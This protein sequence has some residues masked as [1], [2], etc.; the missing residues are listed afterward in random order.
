MWGFVGDAPGRVP[1]SPRLLQSRCCAVASRCVPIAGVPMDLSWS[2]MVGIKGVISSGG[3][4]EAWA[5]WEL[6]S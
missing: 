6:E 2:G 1:V 5:A 4:Q 3:G